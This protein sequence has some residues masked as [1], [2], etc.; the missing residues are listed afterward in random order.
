MM[1]APAAVVVDTDVVFSALLRE[2]T[3]FGELLMRPEPRL[4]V[5]ESVLVELFRHKEKIVRLTRLRED[6]LARFYHV[7]LRHLNLYKEDLVAP[8]HWRAAR[9]LCRG[10]DETDTPHVALALQLNALLWTGD[11]RLREGLAARGF[12]RFFSPTD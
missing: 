2:Q 9:D 5:C 8:E 12:D 10:V 3:R 7:L 4:Y 11:K 6:D 1:E